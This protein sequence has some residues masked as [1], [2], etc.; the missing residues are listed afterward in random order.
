MDEVDERTLYLSAL[1]WAKAAKVSGLCP[2]ASDES[3]EAWLEIDLAQG[4]TSALFWNVM[5]VHPLVIGERE[6]G[7]IPLLGAQTVI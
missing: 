7:L 5:P 6:H 4:Q 3:L 2:R 1:I